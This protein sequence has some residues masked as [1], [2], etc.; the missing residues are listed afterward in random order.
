MRPLDLDDDMQN[1]SGIPGQ[2]IFSMGQR[3]LWLYTTGNRRFFYSDV[4]LLHFVIITTRDKQ[5]SYS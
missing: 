4:K 1:K 3:E 5:L 2:I